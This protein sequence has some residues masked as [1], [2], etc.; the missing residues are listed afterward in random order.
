MK[1]L[2][3]QAVIFCMLVSDGVSAMQP[4]IKVSDIRYA[5]TGCPRGSVS[6]SMTPNKGAINAVFDHFF[7]SFGGKP[8]QKV[9]RCKLSMNLHVPGNK[10]VRLRQIR[11]RGFIDLPANAYT[12]I[13]RNYRFDSTKKQLSKTWQ[14][15][16]FKVINQREPFNTTWSVCGKDVRLEV[17]SMMEVKSRAVATSQVGVDSFDHLMTR[18]YRGERGWKFILDYTPC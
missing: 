9:K 13:V 18:D 12:K 6:V 1:K 10:R 17:D 8:N 2:F 5:G 11:F 15:K 3:T 14:G 7:A 4:N 16:L